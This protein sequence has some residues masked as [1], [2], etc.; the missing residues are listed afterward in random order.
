MR[1]EKAILVLDNSG[2]WRVKA[3]FAGDN[4][5]S[6]IFPSIVGRRKDYGICLLG[7]QN[8]KDVYVGDEVTANMHRDLVL[9]HPTE[10]ALVRHWD[11]MEKV[12]QHALYNELKA[13]PEEH[14]L[15]MVDR[16]DHG[17][18]SSR[19]MATQI[20]FESFN[21]PSFYPVYAE[22]LSVLASGRTT[23]L[24]IHSGDAFTSFTPVYEGIALRHRPNQSQFG[25]LDMT[26]YLQKCLSWN[27]HEVDAEVA[28]DIKE[29][30]CYVPPDYSNEF[31]TGA[32]YKG[33]PY[34]LPDGRVITVADERIRP[35]QMLFEGMSASEEAHCSAVN[36]IYRCIEFIRADLAANVVL[37]GGSMRFPGIVDRMRS[38]M[39][40]RADPKWGPVKVVRL[41]EGKYPAWTGGSLLASLSTFSQMAIS[42][43]E[44]NETGPSIVNR[45]C[46]S[47]VME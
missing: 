17:R 32:A 24:D 14:P 46:I 31:S 20:V 11:D 38:E 12:W 33:Q 3:G 45:K 40:D 22:V 43:A 35:P 42:A 37:S 16:V 25:G 27:G 9:K 15:L 19:E 39:Q 44:Y 18:D 21:V 10:N 4:E 30:L 1:P 13:E 5:P 23:G 34:T 7:A 28:K 26:A 47:A 29:R 2:S 6:V 8:L 36:M 41:D